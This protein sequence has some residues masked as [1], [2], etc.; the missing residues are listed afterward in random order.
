MPAPALEFGPWVAANNDS[1]HTKSPQQ[2]LS[3]ISTLMRPG[4]PM[5]KEYLELTP[6]AADL[7]SVL[8]TLS[9]VGVLYLS[10]LTRP[11]AGLPRDAPLVIR[12]R[13]RAVT[14]VTIAALL[15]SCFLTILT[16]PR[17]TWH[18]VASL[19]GLSVGLSSTLDIF[20]CFLLT[21]VLFTGPLLQRLWF[22]D[23]WK[24][25]KGDNEWRDL[26]DDVGRIFT[27]WV[28]WRNYIA[29]RMSLFLPSGTI[30]R[31][32]SSLRRGI[33]HPQTLSVSNESPFLYTC[34]GGNTK[35]A[36]R[37]R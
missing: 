2:L 9:Y 22:E 10:P 19:L 3:Y 33:I 35:Q 28:G 17:R 25:L 12:S 6:F 1:F 16:T 20:R 7:F 30:M 31:E 32:G 34:A 14:V 8:Y 26:R 15:F 5:S 11:R 27:T 37:N 21:A 4:I 23:G 13:I 36:H 18:D 24:A 29:V